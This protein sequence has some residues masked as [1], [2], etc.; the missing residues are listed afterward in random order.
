MTTPRFTMRLEPELKDWL[1][2]EAK[3]KDRSAAYVAKKT[4]QDLKD[5]TEAKAQVIQEAIAEADKGVF[6][7]E[8]RMTVW[9]ES[10][11][12]DH[13]LPEPQADIFPNQA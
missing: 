11:G 4:I 5:K 13:E 1:E 9:F 2:A 10:L 6:I 8:E 12:T 7:S 3:R